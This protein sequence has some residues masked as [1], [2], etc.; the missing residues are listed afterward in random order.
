MTAVGFRRLK[1]GVHDKVTG[2]IEKI[3][4]VE[5]KQDKG[6]TVSAEISGL[7]SEPVKVYASNV[8]YYVIQ[9]GT[10]DV[11]VEFGILDLPEKLNDA[12]LGYKVDDTNGWA[13]I[14]DDTEPPFCSII[15]ESENLKGEAVM[16][17]IFKGKFSRE[18]MSLQTKEGEN[19]EPEA[20]SYTFSPIASD[21]ED[22]TKGQ[23]VA[24]YTGND[25]AAEFEKLVIPATTVIP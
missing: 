9:K 8:P 3:Q 15:L 2:E 25:K 16:L 22:E 17:G 13:M 24:K 14:G 12:I 19:V 11:S 20:D 1:I 10:G 5:G 21:R 6:G 4:V 23:T 7:S 18:A